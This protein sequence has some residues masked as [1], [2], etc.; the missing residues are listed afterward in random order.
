MTNE[1]LSSRLDYVFKKPALFKQ[2]LTHRSY[3]MQNN[4][5]L[6]FLGDSIL[7]CVI[8]NQL[9]QHHAKLSEGDL[10]RIRAHLVNQHTLHEIADSLKLGEYILLGEGEVK[11]G[12][13][14]RPSILADALEAIFG[15]IFLDS[16]FKSAEQVI[17]RLYAPLLTDLDPKTLGKDPKTSLLNG[18]NQLHN[19]KNVFISDGACMTST[20]TQNPSL[21]YMAITARAANHAVELLKKNE[22]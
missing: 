22:L 19:C 6:E 20:S 21:T 18:W 1:T 13:N 9:F 17:T 16:D 7:N 10:S 8:A 3:G 5:R 12:G 4:E 11:S 15:A 14:R 2:A